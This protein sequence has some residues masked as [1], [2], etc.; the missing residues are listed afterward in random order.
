MRLGLRHTLILLGA[1]VG[2]LLVAL[3]RTWV[4]VAYEESIT[5]AQLTQDLSGSELAPGAQASA[6]V[7][8]AGTAALVAL[9]GWG[10]VVVGA[11]IAGAGVAAA[12]ALVP[13]TSGTQLG[14]RFVHHFGDCQPEGGCGIS[15]GLPVFHAPS[16]VWVALLGCV[17]VVL[18]GLNV[19]VRGRRWPGLSSGYEAPESQPVAVPEG[20]ITDKGTWDALDRGDD[21]TA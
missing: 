19:V 20:P 4:T 9:R 18:A 21:P 11:L 8:L 6:Y 13:L 17:L 5:I 12:V 16:W 3:A 7:A 10:R 1:G 15:G 2:L 14:D